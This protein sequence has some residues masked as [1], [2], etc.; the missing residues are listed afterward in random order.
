MGMTRRAVE[1]LVMNLEEGG[2]LFKGA[3]LTM[4]IRLS[5]LRVGLFNQRS[6]PFFG[7]MGLV[8]PLQIVLN[9]SGLM[10]YVTCS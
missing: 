2:G 5:L 10:P 4:M 6:K 7:D 1:G 8:S 3:H 9:V